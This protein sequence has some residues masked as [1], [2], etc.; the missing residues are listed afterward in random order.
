MAYCAI[1]PFF[2]RA[3]ALSRSSNAGSIRAS[4]PGLTASISE[5]FLSRSLSYQA[6]LGVNVHP[7][8]GRRVEEAAA[9]YTPTILEWE[10]MSSSLRWG[11]RCQLERVL[12][13]C[14]SMNTDAHFSN[15][16]QILSHAHLWCQH[17]LEIPRCTS[18]GRRTAWRSIRVS[19]DANS[20]LRTE[21]G[22][23]ASCRS[24]F[25]RRTWYIDHHVA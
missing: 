25:G 6:F 13:G 14:C 12:S 11:H 21:D 22:R 24:P 15:V 4:P 7:E 17:V 3:L 20:T 5:M 8:I 19:R 2:A 9:Q 1:T 10:T 16:G 18:C 23:Q